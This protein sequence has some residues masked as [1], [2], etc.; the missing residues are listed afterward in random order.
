MT[1]LEEHA[2][3]PREQ[4]LQHLTRTADDLSAAVKGQSE[5]TLCR[6]PDGKNRAAKEVVCHLR[7]TEEVFGAR[8]EQVPA[9]DADPTLVATDPDRWA[10]ERQYLVNDVDRALT[11]FRRRRGETLEIFGKLTGARW[12]KGAIHP[13]LGRITLDRFLSIMAWHDENHLDQVARALEGRA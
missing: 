6:R 3:R 11:A 2:K 12:E 9:M 1:T 13:T 7:D 10:D 4:R 8:M 5:A